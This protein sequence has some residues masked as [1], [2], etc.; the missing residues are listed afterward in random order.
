MTSSPDL[1]IYL[2][3]L[4]LFWLTATF[5]VYLFS[6][7]VNRRC[8]HSPLVNPIIIAIFILST[9]LMM[10]GTKYQTY[11][12]GAQFIHFLLGPATVALAIPLYKQM[13]TIRRFLLP[14]CIALL[15]GSL[16]AIV[17]AVGLAWIFGGTP[18][19]LL[20]LAPKSVTTPI[21]MGV[22]QAIGGIPALTAALVVLT[23]MVGATF[24]SLI[25]SL[26]RIRDTKAQGLALGVA[27]HGLGTARALQLGETAGAFSSLGMSLN[28]VFTAILIPILLQ[29][30]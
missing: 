15:V 14:I 4:S 13:H 1:W 21:A 19:I 16:T 8:K 5:V 23:G 24:G 7:W 9:A 29:F 6:L 25:F 12:D 17:T 2:Q 22:S 30:F 3:G 28:G 11:F 10:S 20:S 27:S 26:L 18:Q